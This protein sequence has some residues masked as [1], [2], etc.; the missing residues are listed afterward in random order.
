MTKSLTVLCLGLPAGA[1]VSGN[2]CCAMAQPLS[3]GDMSRWT[4]WWPEKGQ[5]D[6]RGLQRQD[7]A[8]TQENCVISQRA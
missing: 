3:E 2:G 4:G 5:A 7:S 6:T 1:V 8:E